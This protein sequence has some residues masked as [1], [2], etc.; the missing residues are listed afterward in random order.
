M[1]TDE[2]RR[3]AYNELLEA[4]ATLVQEATDL[5]FEM[6]PD[7]GKDRAQ[8]RVLRHLNHKVAKDDRRN[9]RI[10]RVR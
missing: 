6:K 1:I 5:S 10:R 2:I 8:A 9:D 3:E 4:I 7:R